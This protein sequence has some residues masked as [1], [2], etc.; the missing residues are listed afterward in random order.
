M[1]DSF[2]YFNRLNDAKLVENPVVIAYP[3]VIHVSALKP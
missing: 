1:R 3:F 2:H